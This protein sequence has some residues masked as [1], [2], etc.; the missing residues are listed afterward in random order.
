[1]RVI[2]GSDING[3]EL[4]MKIVELLFSSYTQNIV[5]IGFNNKTSENNIE[6]LIQEM[7]HYLN[8]KDNYGILISSSGIDMSIK[9]NKNKEIRA[10]NC[11]NEEIAELARRKYNTNVLVLGYDLKYSENFFN[12]IVIIN[13]FLNTEYKENNLI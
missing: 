5:D 2:L 7:S 13:K 1:M 8:E 9:A 6:N 4:K 12:I 3:H 11:Y 10:V